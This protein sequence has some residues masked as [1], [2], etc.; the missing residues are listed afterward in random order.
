MSVAA[1]GTGRK[2]YF[3]HEF[4]S[5][6]HRPL[7]HQIS[8]LIRTK[9]FILALL[10]T[11]KPIFPIWTTIIWKSASAFCL[12]SILSFGQLVVEVCF[13]FLSKSMV[14]ALSREA[15]VVGS[16]LTNGFAELIFIPPVFLL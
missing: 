11:Q 9:L 6:F 3:T 5:I 12:G 15:W 13:L 8:Q 10:S 4:G 2:P 16:S 1:A 14:I 7:F